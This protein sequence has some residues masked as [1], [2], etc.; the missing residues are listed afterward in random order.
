[1]NAGGIVALAIVGYVAFVACMELAIA[2]VQP[3]M[4]IGVVLTTTDEA[5]RSSSR[6]LAGFEFEDRLYVSSNHWLRG[7][8]RQA[9]AQP[10]VELEIGDT[11]SRRLAVPVVGE[12]RD[13]LADAYRMGFVLRFISGFA[14]SRFLRLD[15]IT[16]E[17]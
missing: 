13:R 10:E 1:V 5:G 15:P 14:P 8:Y 2:L 9:L 4:D 6:T 17:G 11:T 12:E 16:G 3:E 7:W